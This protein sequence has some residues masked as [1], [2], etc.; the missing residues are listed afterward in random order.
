[1]VVAGVVGL[2]QMAGELETWVFWFAN[3]LNVMIIPFAFYFILFTK[4]N[5]PFRKIE[6]NNPPQTLQEK[7]I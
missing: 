7:G 5:N 4:F 6:D 1:M 2:Q 3:I